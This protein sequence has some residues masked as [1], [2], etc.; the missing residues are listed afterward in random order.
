MFT[1][2]ILNLPQVKQALNDL[3]KNHVPEASFRA[4]NDTAY[5]ALDGV[6]AEMRSVFDRPT[7]FA[8][9]AFMVWRANMQTQRAEVKER[10]SVGP[11]HFL[12]V[13]QSGGVRPNTALEKLIRS[14]VGNTSHI[15]AITPGP[16]AK[17][18]AFGNWASGERNQALSGIK[19]QRDATSNTTKASRA[20]SKNKGRASYFVPGPE[21]KLSPGIYRRQGSRG[22]PEKV[23]N[24]TSNMPSYSKRIDYRDVVAKVAEDIYERHFAHRL[25]LLLP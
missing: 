20:L 4:L 24:F 19:A 16:A 17:L 12:K 23:A 10:P 13:Q 3:A 22:T 1:L 6:K 5:D 18:D 14:K 21:A 2:D 15:A 9:N 11:R 7:P 8:L 25:K